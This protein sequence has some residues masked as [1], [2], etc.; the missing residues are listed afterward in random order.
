MWSDNEALDVDKLNAMT[1]NDQWLFE[2]MPRAKYSGNVSKWDGVKILGTRAVVPANNRPANA[3]TV[4]FG[5]TFSSGC[6]P[7]VV[8]T[9]IPTNWQRRY[10]TVVTGIG[11]NTVADKNGCVVTV[12]SA[13]IN[14]KQMKL[15][16]A[17]WVQVIAI[18]W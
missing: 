12:S 14:P 7:I 15:A 11:K 6:Q 9:A 4:Y 18:G 3:A 16:A 8:A 2:N 1:N 10:H 17:V 13:E 5:N